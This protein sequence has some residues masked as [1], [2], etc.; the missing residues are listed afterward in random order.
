MG[1]NYL[2][3]LR[4]SKLIVTSDANLLQVVIRLLEVL[5]Q[6]RVVIASLWSSMHLKQSRHFIHTYSTRIVCEKCKNLSP[7]SMALNFSLAT[8][9]PY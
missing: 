8:S 3:F 5:I 9:E 2:T 6:E 1:T 7:L 4:H